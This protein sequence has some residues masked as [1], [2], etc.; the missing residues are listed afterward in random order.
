MSAATRLQTRYSDVPKLD[1]KGKKREIDSLLDEL[2]RDS[3]RAFVKERSRRDEL[4][5]ESVDSLLDW[6]NDIWSSVYELKVNYGE[7]HRCLL[8]SAEVLDK[9]NVTRGG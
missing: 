4:L 5:S 2:A 3:K 1:L 9:I 8:F 6:M 7:G